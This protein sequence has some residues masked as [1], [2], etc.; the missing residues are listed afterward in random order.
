MCTAYRLWQCSPARPGR[1]RHTYDIAGGSLPGDHEWSSVRSVPIIVGA[2]A[3]PTKTMCA[4]TLL[5]MLR[6][7][8]HRHKNDIAGGSLPGDH[9]GLASS[10]VKHCHD[11]SGRPRFVGQCYHPYNDWRRHQH[12]YD[13]AGGLLQGDHDESRY[14][15]Y[16]FARTVVLW[17]AASRVCRATLP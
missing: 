10:G 7:G 6:P 15:D 14:A 8:R 5:A 2:R 1:H 3:L 17:L 16:W 11:I 12:A 4:V 13:I 9:D